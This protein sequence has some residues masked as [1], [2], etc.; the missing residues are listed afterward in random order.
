MNKLETARKLA[1]QTAEQGQDTGKA[2]RVDPES[3]DQLAGVL[4]I[5]LDN[6]QSLNKKQNLLGDGLS[7]KLAPLDGLKK[8]MKDME[9]TQMNLVKQQQKTRRLLL[10]IFF[11]GIV[12][13]LAFLTTLVLKIWVLK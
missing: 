9:N 5:I 6:Q 4:K 2:V 13:L 1:K 3:L 7:K 11:T 10:A 12:P 8:W